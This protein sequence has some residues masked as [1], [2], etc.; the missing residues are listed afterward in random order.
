M[1][2]AFTITAII[3]LL[4]VGLLAS[5][6]ASPP[7]DLDSPP[8]AYETGVDPEAWVMVPAG[9]F[10]SGM[11]DHEL[12][13]DHDYEIMVTDVTNEQYA[14]YLNEAPAAG[15]VKL[16]DGELVGYYAGDEF[17]G[18]N[19]EE[20]IDAG[21][22]LHV[23]VEEPGLRL[24]YDGTTFSA[25]S[26]FEN[27]PMVMVTWFGAKAYCEFNGGR[28]PSELEW[29]KAARGTDGR[30]Y[31]WGDEIERNH[32]NYYSSHDLFEKI[33]GGLGLTTPVGFFSGKS[34]EGYQTLNAVSPFGLYDMAGNV[35]QWTA[36][37]YEDQH[38]RYLRGGSKADYEY[39]LRVWT[40][41]SAGP[42]Y[43]SPNVGFR[44]VRDP[45]E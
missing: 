27:H 8:T 13:I 26:G 31:P 17:H 41:N 12:L 36:D 11:H 22:W 32:A 45:I 16:S 37:D 23:P 19:H 9:E 44:C 25:K 1:T 24:A 20:R 5:G 15:T 10:L 39:N 3:G 40:R 43:F 2:R 42:E 14:R 29:E 38:Y 34:Y 30:P 7:P 6:C 35:W 28:L 18:G 33:V 4:T 21:N